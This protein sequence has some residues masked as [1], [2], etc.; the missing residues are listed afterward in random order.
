MH[1]PCKCH[2]CPLA[3]SEG[4]NIC[5]PYYVI[6]ADDTLFELICRVFPR[7]AIGSGRRLATCRSSAVIAVITTVV[8]EGGTALN[9]T[10][11]AVFVH[12]SKVLR[13]HLPFV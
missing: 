4:L 6:D 8:D 11:A 13:H 5:L 1:H 9:P 7:S 12:K 2:S 10:V 3:R